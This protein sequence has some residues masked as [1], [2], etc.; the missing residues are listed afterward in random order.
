M[1]T[2]GSLI[3]VKFD[4]SYISVAELKAQ[5]DPNPTSPF[6]N[7]LKQVMIEVVRGRFAFQEL[8]LNR[9]IPQVKPMGIEEFLQKWWGSKAESLSK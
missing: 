9:L 4:V 1:L 5:I 7:F 3:G 8:N 2:L 6:P